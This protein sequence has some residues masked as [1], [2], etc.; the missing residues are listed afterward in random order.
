MYVNVN[1]GF[2][3]G[4]FCEGGA[5]RRVVGGQRGVGER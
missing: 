4:T 3:V 2:E 1:V 5:G